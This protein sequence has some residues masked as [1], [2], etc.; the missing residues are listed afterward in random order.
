LI[1]QEEQSIQFRILIIKNYDQM[2]K[3]WKEAGLSSRPSRRDS[4][5]SIREQMTTAPS[6]FIGAFE[7]RRLI[8]V[9]VAS[10]DG[11]K[12]WIN[13]LAV[14]PDYRRRGIATA[15][16][17]ETENALREKGIHIFAALIMESNVASKQLFRELGYEEM[18]EVFYFSKRDREDA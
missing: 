16:V 5:E 12:G 13:R 11:R 3:L 1:V 18:K 8:G 15:L 10:S 14:H 4:R 17:A 6:L 9:V 2:V 7:S